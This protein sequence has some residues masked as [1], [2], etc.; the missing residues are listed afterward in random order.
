MLW[1]KHGFKFHVFGTQ[2]SELMAF[3]SN[4]C[5]QFHFSFVELLW[6]TVPFHKSHQGYLNYLK[7]E[8]INLVIHLFN[9]LSEPRLNI[10][11]NLSIHVRN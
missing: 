4:S 7:L 10:F 6:L 3:E 8:I 5:F 1:S 11:Q 2:Q 9:S